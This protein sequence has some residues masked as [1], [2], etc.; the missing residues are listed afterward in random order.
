MQVKDKSSLR[1]R[2][3]SILQMPMFFMALLMLFSSV[4]QGQHYNFTTYTIAN[5]MPSNQVNAVH[6]DKAGKLW[7]GT[8]NGACWF[9]GTN[10]YRFEQDNPASFNPVKAFYEDNKGNLWMAITR[11]GIGVF[12]G[13]RKKFYTI[14]NGLLSNNATAI[15]QDKTGRYWI[16]TSEGLNSFDG[17]RFSSYTILKGL[18][19]NEVTCLLTD[20]KGNIWIGTT[21]GLSKYD[22]KQFT[23]FTINEGLTGNII[24]QISE[25]NDGSIWAGTNEG[26][27]IYQNGKFG[28]FDI[29]KGVSVKKVTA[30]LEDYK[31]NKWFSTYGNGMCLIDHG[32]FFTLTKDEG[33]TDNNILCMKEDNEGNIWIGTPRGLCRY[34]GGRFITYTTE[35][36]F[37]DNRLLT[38]YTDHLNR[39]WFGIVNGGL[40][41]IHGNTVYTP[42]FEN[43]LA[44][45]TIWSIAQDAAQNFWFG[46]ST[47]PALVS[48]DLSKISFPFDLLNNKII[49][50]VMAHRNGSLWF[51]TD[52]GIYIYEHNNLRVLNKLN[53]LQNDNIR[54]LFQDRQGLVWVGTLQGM[55]FM[56]NETAVSLNDKLNLNKTPITSITQDIE[57]NIIFSTFDFGVYIFSKKKGTTAIRHLE[58][59]NGLFNNRILTVA[60]DNN[61]LWMGT[62]LGIDRIDWNTY[63]KRDFTNIIHF[64]KSNGFYGVETNAATYDKDGFLWF[65]TVNGAVRY[66]PN[67][68][69]SKS[70]TPVVLLQ[71]IKAYMRE[72]N[73]S[74]QGFS[75]DSITGLPVNPV[76]PYGYNNLNFHFTG[77]YFASPDALQ[78][79]WKLDGFDDYWVPATNLNIANYSNL[80]PGNYTFQ[81]QATANGHDWSPSLTYDF[82]VKSPVWRT[83]FFYFIYFVALTLLI[84]VILKLRTRSLRNAQLLLRQKINERTHQLRENNMQLA[85]LSI[86]ASETDNAVMIFDHNLNLEFVNEGYTRMHGYTMDEIIRKQGSKLTQLSY[87]EN[88]KTIIKDCLEEHKSVIYETKITHRNGQQLWT[89]STLTPVFN[90][91]D[92]LSNIVVIDTDITLHKKMEEQIRESLDEK[93]I[94]LKEIHHRVKNNLQIIVSLFNLQSAYLQDKASHKILKEGQDRIRSMALIHDRFY[95]SDGT[96]RIDFDDYIKRLCETIMQSQNAN[97]QKIRLQIEAEKI[98][99]DIDTAVPCGL[100]INELVSNAIKHAFADDGGTIWV[101]FKKVDDHYLLSIADNGKGLPDGKDFETADT[102]GIQLVN[103]LSDQID[104]KVTVENSNGLKVIIKFKPSY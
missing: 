28:A 46:T 86:V 80:P 33:L 1:I 88:I 51:G 5:G 69:Y 9:D 64:D 101:T 41:Y 76:F 7:I 84:L 40:N 92:E 50:A 14:D 11:G 16:G 34:S 2:N 31:K 26:I 3:Q 54:Y 20:S 23:N 8:M 21:N 65:A 93:N 55:Y 39:I 13:I 89:S 48:T 60:S 17:T 67:S 78:Y 43:I 94:L 72:V 58:V 38:A 6:Q 103:V 97:P 63:L 53:G 22:G 35:N 71:S 100:I 47:G 95:Q 15:T 91:K 96:S 4:V 36:G 70:T 62:P 61:Y 102:L 42:P 75:I 57:G 49:Y 12:N 77:I 99:L 24:Y 27:S 98:S 74:E 25:L 45:A 44:R 104:G 19:S 81:V 37:N 82:K 85:K 79:R 30:I 56:H 90:D 59:G 83:N 18:V 87:N 29:N 73:W 66:N 10:F 52:R 32:H 68:G